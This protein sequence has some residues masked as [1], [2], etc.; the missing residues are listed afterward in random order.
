MARREYTDEEL[1]V[2]YQKT[3]LRSLEMRRKVLEKARGGKNNLTERDQADIL[4]LKLNMYKP[5]QIVPSIREF[6]RE[7]R[8]AQRKRYEKALEKWDPESGDPK[9][10]M[11]KQDSIIRYAANLARRDTRNVSKLRADAILHEGTFITGEKINK[12]TGEVTVK[13][14]TRNELYYL[15]DEELNKY[16]WDPIRRRRQELIDENK[17][18]G[19]KGLIGKMLSEHLASTIAREFFGSP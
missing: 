12:T 3:Y 18:K 1:E 15:S 7:E 17:R 5:G 4:N 6:I 14:I 19:G 9:P 2:M 8:T 16:V 11:P 10:K 13:K